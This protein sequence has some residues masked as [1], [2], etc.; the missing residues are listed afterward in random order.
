MRDRTISSTARTPQ[1]I[2]GGRLSGRL[3]RLGAYWPVMSGS[4]ANRHG[5]PT[6]TERLC[7]RGLPRFRRIGL[8]AFERRAPQMAGLLRFVQAIRGRNW[9]CSRHRPAA[10]AL[11]TWPDAPVHIAGFDPASFHSPGLW[12]G[13]VRHRCHLTVTFVSNECTKNSVELRGF[14]P[15]TSCMPCKSDGLC[16]RA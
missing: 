1:P 11:L 16:T 7:A 14:E 10:S 15:L 9:T 3:R 6:R 13:K 5:T 8:P 12:H 4:P 2:G